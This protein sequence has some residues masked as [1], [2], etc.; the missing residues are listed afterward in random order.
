MKKISLIIWCVASMLTAQA[1][2]D[3]R[4]LLLWQGQASVGNKI[5][6]T[7]SVTVT[8]A[9]LT[10][11]RDLEIDLNGFDLC[12][13]N[14]GTVLHPFKGNITLKNSLS[15]TKSVKAYFPFCFDAIFDKGVTDPAYARSGSLEVN[16]GITF[17]PGGFGIVDSIS[18]ANWM[19]AGKH[20]RIKAG[21][22]CHFGTFVGARFCV[23]AFLFEKGSRVCKA[24]RDFMVAGHGAAWAALNTVLTALTGDDR[25]FSLDDGDATIEVTKVFSAWPWRD[26]LYVGYRVS[27]IKDIGVD[28]GVQLYVSYDGTEKFLYGY[29]SDNGFEHLVTSGHH[30]VQFDTDGVLGTGWG[31]FFPKNLNTRNTRL[32]AV[33]TQKIEGKWV[34]IKRSSKEGFLIDNRAKKTVELGRS[35]PIAYSGVG[36]FGLPGLLTFVTY[37]TREWKSKD[38]YDLIFHKK[39]GSIPYLDIDLKNF[40]EA[41]IEVGTKDWTPTKKTEYHWQHVNGIEIYAATLYV[42]DRVIPIPQPRTDL[43]YNGHDQTGVAAGDGFTLGGVTH[44]ANAGSYTAS[45]TPKSGVVWADGTSETKTIVWS[46]APK[47]MTAVEV[48]LPSYAF[49]YTGSA[50]KPLPNVPGLVKDRDY[51]VSWSN[52]TNPGQASVTVTGQ[53]NYTGSLTVNFTITA[54][55]I[56]VPTAKS[57]TYDGTLKTGVASSAEYV[58]GSTYEAVNANHYTATVTPAAGRIWEDGTTAAKNLDWTISRRSGPT[59]GITC[60]PASLEYLGHP[61]TTTV[62]VKDPV[63]GETLTAGKDYTVSY[64]N[65]DGVGTATAI[66]T[67]TGNYS[68]EAKVN[69]TITA[70]ALKSGNTSVTLSPSSFTSDGLRPWTPTATVKVTVDGQERTLAAGTDYEVTYQNNVQPGTAKAIIT[71]KGIYAGSV[72]KEFAITGQSLADATV[73]LSPASLTYPVTTPPAVTVTCG[74]TLVAGTDYTVSFAGLSAAGTATVTV[75][76]CGAYFGSKSVDFTINRKSIS[77]LSA[78]V[79]TPTVEYD[80]TKKTPAVTIAGLTPGKD[81]TVSYANNENAGTATAT[82]TGIGN[83][84]G[85]LVLSPAFT[86][87]PA[88]LSGA[89]VTVTPSS[90]P[91]DGMPKTPT[92]VTVKLG[93]KTLVSGLDY[94]V[95]VSNNTDPGRATVTVTGLGNYKDTATGTFSIAKASIAGKTVTLTPTAVV[96]DGTAWRPTVAIDGLTEGVDFTVTY[97]SDF[98]S[99]GTH[100]VTIVAIGEKYTGS[101]TVTFTI[102]V[103]PVI[104]PTAKAIEGLV[105][106]GTEQFGVADSADAAYYTLSGVT[107]A[108]AIGTYTATAT[109]KDTVSTKWA[110]GTT[111]PKSV[112]WKIKAAQVDP[113]GVLNVTN[114]AQLTE[115]LPRFV[116][117]GTVTIRVTGFTPEFPEGYICKDLGDGVYT[118]ARV[119]EATTSFRLDTRTTRTLTAAEAETFTHSATAWGAED[120][121][122]TATIAYTRDG[123]AAELG[124]YADADTATWTPGADGT[125]VFTHQPSNLKATFVVEGLGP[126]GSGTASDPYVVYN[127]EEFAEAVARGKAAGQSPIYIRLGANITGPL[128]VEDAI[129]SLDMN[130]F[131]ITSGDDGEGHGYHALVVTGTGR[132]DFTGTG[133]VTGGDGDLEGATAVAGNYTKV[134]TVKLVDGVTGRGTEDA[135]YIVKT[136]AEFEN[137]VKIGTSPVWIRLGA[138]IPE[139]V[140]VNENKDIVC[141]LYG[142]AMTG[143]AGNP[144]DA[145]ARGGRPAIDV[146]GTGKLELQNTKPDTTGTV[147]GGRGADGNPPGAGGAGV[148]GG[149]QVTVGA[150]VVVRG[151]NGGL[152][153]DTGDVVPDAPGGKGVEPED[154]VK[155]PVEGEIL[156]GLSGDGTEKHPYLVADN[157][158]VERAIAA[159]AGEAV[160]MRL[161]AD[162]TDTMIV[163]NGTKGVNIDTYGHNVAGGKDEDGFGKPGVSVLG[164]GD[165][166]FRNTGDKK[167]VVAG[168]DGKT[169]GAAVRLAKTG[170]TYSVESGAQIDFVAGKNGDGSKNYPYEVSTAEEIEELIPDSTNNPVYFKL[171]DDITDTPVSIDEDKDVVI[172]LNGHDITGVT[173]E[174]AI[175]VTGT[176]NLTITDSS[177]DANA[178][179]TVKG[180]DGAS[181]KDG[182][183]GVVI[184]AGTV[185]VDS[186]ATVAG[187]DGGGNDWGD[188]GK[189]AEGV[190]GRSETTNGGV[191]VAGSDGASGGGTQSNPYKVANKAEFDETMA[192][193]VAAGQ[194]E[195][196]VVLTGD[197]AGSVAVPENMSV[198][199][200]LGGHGMTGTSGTAGS[201]DGQ[202]AVTI[203]GGAALELTGS[204]TVTGGDGADD[205]GENGQPGAGAAAIAGGTPTK[206]QDVVL[207]DGRDGRTGDGSKEHPYILKEPLA[208]IAEL[209]VE[210]T[211]NDPVYIKLTEDLDETLVLNSGKNIV[212]DTNGHQIDGGTDKETGKG[213]PAIAVTAGGTLAITNGNDEV[214]SV[215]S[216]GDGHPGAPAVTGVE[217]TVSADDNVI[218]RDGLDGHGTEEDP[219]EVADNDDVAAALEKGTSPVHLKL[220]EDFD[221]TLVIDADEKDVVLDTNGHDVDGGA[222]EDGFGQPGISFTGTGSLTVENTDEAKESVI[223]GGDGKTGGK[224]VTGTTPIVAKDENVTFVDGRNGDGSA[225]YPYEVSTAKEIEEL[226]PGCTNNPACFVLT[227]DITDTPI[228]IDENT[229]V[230]IDLKGHD[231]TGGTDATSGNGTMAIAFMG[232]GDLTITDSSTGAKGTVRGGD[233]KDGGAT[234]AGGN[235]AAG[236]YMA[237]G[238]ATVING[239]TVRGGNGGNSLAFDA[240]FGQPGVSGAY[241]TTADGAAEGF[242]VD[243]GNGVKG[244]GTPEYPY[245]V[246]T[247]DEL[248]QVVN[249][250]EQDPIAVKLLDDIYPG[251]TLDGN[252]E[253]LID[254]NGHGIYGAGGEE[255][256]DDGEPAITLSPAAGDGSLELK[257]PGVVQGGDGADVFGEDVTPGKGGKAIVPD[258]ATVGEGVEVL[259]GADGLNTNGRTYYV[260]TKAELEYAVN[261]AAG[262]SNEVDVVLLNDITVAGAS[263][264]FEEYPNAV[265]DLYGHSIV[266]TGS[267]SDGNGF[268]AIKVEGTGTGCL[269]F[270][271]S[272]ET[273]GY[274]TGA[275]AGKKGGKGGAAYDVPEGVAV[276]G[277]EGVVFQ[278]GLT[279]TGTSNDPYLV[280]DREEFERAVEKGTEPVYIKLVATIWDSLVTDKHTV[281]DLNGFDVRAGQDADGNGET[282][283]TVE[284]GKNLTLTG[285]GNVYGGNGAGRAA[286]DAG[287]GGAGIN[288]GTGTLTVGSGAEVWGGNG[289]DSDSGQ[290]G[291]GAL[292]VSPE[293]A[294]VAGAGGKANVH[295]GED[296][297]SFIEM[298]KDIFYDQAEVGP[299]EDGGHRVILTG[300]VTGPVYI[301]DSVGKLEIDMNGYSITGQGGMGGENGA[302]AVVVT[303]TGVATP[304][305]ISF[306]TGKGDETSGNRVTGG[307]GG[308]STTGN[309]GN[310]G[311][312]IRFEEGANAR[313]AV[314]EDVVVSGG[315]GGR[316]CDATDADAGNGGAGGTGF[317][318]GPDALTE[319]KGEIRGGNGGAGGTSV[320]GNG[321][322]GGNGGDSGLGYTLVGEGVPPY[323]DVKG[324]NGGDGGDSRT[325]EAGYGG[326]G[327]DYELDSEG[328]SG[329]NG[330][331]ADAKLVILE[332]AFGAPEKAEVTQNEDG[333]YTVELKDDITDCPVRVPDTVGSFVIDLKGHSII[334]ANG[335]EGSSDGTPAIVIGNTGK[336]L[337]GT[338]VTIVNSFPAE[339]GHVTG[340]SGRNG[341]PGGNGASGVVVE[342]GQPTA[343]R[344]VGDGV[345]VEGGNGGDTYGAYDP[346]K[347]AKGVS[348][349]DAAASEGGVIR[350][351]ADGKPQIL[352]A[353]VQQHY[354]WD[355]KIDIDYT[356]LGDVADANLTW[357]VTPE[358]SDQER[359]EAPIAP[360]TGSVVD[361]GLRAEGTHR[362]TIDTAGALA[363]FAGK[364]QVALTV[365]ASRNGMKM[366]AVCDFRTATEGQPAE[367]ATADDFR[368][369]AYSARGWSSLNEAGTAEVR[370]TVGGNTTTALTATD[371]SMF[372]WEP[373]AAGLTKLE[374]VVNGTVVDTAWFDVKPSAVGDKP[375]EVEVEFGGDDGNKKIVLPWKWIDDIFKPTEEEKEKV[376]ELVEKVEEVLEN[377]LTR[378]QNAIFGRTGEP[379]VNDVG[380]NEKSKTLTVSDCEPTGLIK[381]LDDVDA[382]YVLKRL[383][384]DEWV[385]VPGKVSKT[386]I[387]NIALEPDDPTGLYRIYIRFTPTET[388]A[389]VEQGAGN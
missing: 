250:T 57:Y 26:R 121:D 259:D 284:G 63:T 252:K 319:N 339:G 355:G 337:P 76:G 245:E 65:N 230:V 301:P 235:G 378:W 43:V 186:G 138:N 222:D 325:G 323:G 78:T 293:G 155:E 90:V 51:T 329:S 223:S 120:G 29:T 203:G 202:A 40:K 32:T 128:A 291:L 108:T 257:G 306:V 224:S 357:T 238:T 183:S 271:N 368:K 122:G 175:D 151:G 210:D 55:K 204:G 105:F 208:E 70:F 215:I 353:R 360:A 328:E 160:Y 28:Y 130:G 110:D 321:G 131:N 161:V 347:G 199:L 171:T 305:E 95:S 164:T 356:V 148:L 249:E 389:S 253:I 24:I 376:D 185:T 279:G 193:A 119:S 240:G 139:T 335:T 278:N 247:R 265:I 242:V 218:L 167:S 326:F 317:A 382:V 71:G 3:M 318:P 52:N 350:D 113:D 96:Y 64:E 336:G 53:G 246:R 84:T 147:T 197:I 144:A 13:K 367:I 166:G 375:L 50:I 62:T 342:G 211:E 352:I 79:A 118:I 226:I 104:V 85:T 59:G 18:S 369:V 7:K 377:G 303:A 364:C 34:E 37:E 263:V 363:G 354:P 48:A 237:V 295:D 261:S 54:K 83:Y 232:E 359:A 14:V 287:H 264:T 116:N 282:G 269:A 244:N 20:I 388:A 332:D 276:S 196:W 191:I 283:I 124:E 2:D 296:G 288:I 17:G 159:G 262:T 107:A 314:G 92:G 5:K 67:Y 311:A 229:D 180:G 9:E 297:Q 189:G 309:G 316:G 75:T 58:R 74:R 109:L 315:Q 72:T 149:G 195:I 333:T 152:S 33:L 198:H 47:Q 371:E 25:F 187:G 69:F 331:A 46:I 373:T 27:G 207:A 228:T 93:G 209:I 387:F 129:V 173:G 251:V 136:R 358:Q 307:K 206:G 114:P 38:I 16:E 22:I 256:G 21:A 292:G 384:G 157:G 379:S 241:A 44:A 310:G 15:A 31:S 280:S 23:G 111:A 380:V 221:E 294:D 290:P 100:T 163:D 11:E 299:T 177:P 94:T 73:T 140:T 349:I 156:P 182:A 8:T 36:F 117:E 66:I 123:R 298:L 61:M 274:V 320:D 103:K 134:D 106:D 386:P 346:G 351:G 49:T 372:T 219:Y 132:V 112:V 102:L 281:L 225:D 243:G 101:K 385:D 176:G 381:P 80:G 233:G 172:D 266:A 239:A 361:A 4:D 135:P 1:A 234:A 327:G 169:G 89:T 300:N 289:G 362:V 150:N 312:G 179:G 277:S 268:P 68:G 45:A 42:V 248:I 178:K 82:L 194:T 81:F 231:I 273:V 56:P 153:T 35:Y 275:D 366:Q 170:A 345:V 343:V 184:T 158:D 200:D 174:P 125:Y 86:I 133:T 190:T 313:I 302:D 10:V 165:V 12:I 254:L 341:V 220:T 205:W 137:A 258:G 334:G 255:A 87:T 145:E 88:S 285:S 304:A 324:G 77:D 201:K 330:M 115:G 340:G 272:S 344:V 365:G 348:A 127:A 213:L 19:E 216:G 192:K 146:W 6:L 126:E 168:G 98:T 142:Y 227:G 212:L 188:G 91:Y 383:V 141:D 214:T 97:D 322:L 286:E 338:T 217:P 99:A 162:F 267:D 370:V 308:D 260:R 374:H 143:T 39:I 154:D 270:T 236:V 41:H 181:G 30:E 60:S